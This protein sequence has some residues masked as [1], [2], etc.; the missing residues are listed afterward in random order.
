MSRS[1]RPVA[2]RTIASTLAALLALSG[3]V[4]ARAR[5]DAAQAQAAGAPIV[6]SCGAMQATVNKLKS[7][8]PLQD[9]WIKRSEAKLRAAEDGVRGAQEELQSMALKAAVDLVDRQLE[10]VRELKSGIAKAAASNAAFRFAMASVTRSRN[11]LNSGPL[12]LRSSGLMAPSV[13]KSSAME[14]FLPRAATRTSSSARS[15]LA[16]STPARM[17]RS[18]W[19]RSVMAN[20][21]CRMAQSPFGSHSGTRGHDQCAPDVAC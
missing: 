10:I 4:P 14:P 15:S 20:P 11:P 17:S 13:F 2:V 21:S 19:A 7:G 3:P 16:A 5:A 1:P 9:E 8:L 18:S 6:P 12:V